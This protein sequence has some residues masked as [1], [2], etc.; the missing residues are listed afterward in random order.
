[1]GCGGVSG[2]SGVSGCLMEGGF[3]VLHILAWEREGKPMRALGP[4]A[5]GWTGSK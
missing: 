3:E 5:G 2:V 4:L 1:M